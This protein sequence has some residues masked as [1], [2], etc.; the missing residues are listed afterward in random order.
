[1]FKSFELFVGQTIDQEII[2]NNLVAFS[3]TKVKKTSYEGEF[4]LRGEILDIFPEIGRA[5]V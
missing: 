2:L 4:A 1:M 3:Y 5:H